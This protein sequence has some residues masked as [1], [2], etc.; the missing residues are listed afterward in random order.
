MKKLIGFITFILALSVAFTTHKQ[1]VYAVEDPIVV[2]I[3]AEHFPDD[4]F[5]NLLLYG[6]NYDFSTDPATEIYY[7]A[8]QDGALSK[9]E[10]ENITYFNIGNSLI[11]DL[12]GIEY[13]TS[14]VELNCQHNLIK[15]LDLSKNTELLYLN[16]YHNQ[17]EGIL[18]LTNNKKLIGI[19]THNNPALTGVIAPNSYDLETLNIEN[20]A[21][22]QVDV[23]VYP[24]LSSLNCGLI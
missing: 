17:L 16:C 1:D 11:T 24:K 7:D 12:T 13:F 18:D 8:N 4:A 10:L 3:T 15:K 2:E 6:C 9:Q 22:S 5:R 19:A 23:S 20:T 14:I 21:V